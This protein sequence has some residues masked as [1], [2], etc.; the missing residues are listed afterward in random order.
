MKN[1]FLVLSIIVILIGCTK[2]DI[3]A[4][5]AI[6]FEK[7]NIELTIGEEYQC[8][9]N[10]YPS[11]SEYPNCKWK[12]S[13]ENIVSV[14]S[15]GL[16][17]ANAVGYSTISAYV[18]EVI[19]S[20][21][22]IK[23]LPKHVQTISLDK[24]SLEAYI[25]EEIALSCTV[26]PS[27]ATFKDVY[28]RSTNID[29]AKVDKNGVVYCIR[30]G[31]VDIIAGT[32]E[33]E[34][35]TKAKSDTCHI[36]VKY[37]KNNLKYKF[38]YWDKNCPY[39]LKFGDRVDIW[40]TTNK[41]ESLMSAGLSVRQTD[42]I[43]RSGLAAEIETLE[44]SQFAGEFGFH[45]FPGVLFLGRFD[46]LN[47]LQDKYASFKFGYPIT[48]KPISIKGWYNYK[49]G[50]GDYINADGSVTSGKIDKCG[51]YAVY[52]GI[53]KYS[54][55]LNA[56]NIFSDEKVI[57][58]AKFQGGDTQGNEMS[59]FEAPFIKTGNN[60]SYSEYGI[61]IILMASS[62]GLSYEGAIGSKLVIDDLEVIIE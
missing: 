3:P 55:G 22:V 5:Q 29:I 25:G 56:N 61:S 27:D 46:E 53:D 52:H 7:E 28:W 45:L 35:Y 1:L 36:I 15:N 50:V 10:L 6:M 43:K 30:E 58:I 33:M 54:S 11:K 18:N 23:V 8:K 34:G 31:S 26:L 2:E 32:T 49:A 19:S 40:A 59:L 13:H 44:A 4:L 47:V 51:I 48:E 12:S 42:K 20:T 21:C 14:T 17:K 16:V 38:D 60:R 9:L 24:K 39:E 37:Q 62:E 57:A 41:R